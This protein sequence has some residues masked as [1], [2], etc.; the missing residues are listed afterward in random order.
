MQIDEEERAM[1]KNFNNKSFYLS[2]SLEVVIFSNDNIGT[3]ADVLNASLPFD[4]IANDGDKES[5]DF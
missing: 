2:P 1:D 5:A 3:Y 4:P